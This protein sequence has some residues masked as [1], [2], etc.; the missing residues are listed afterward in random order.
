M[1]EVNNFAICF[2]K[3]I[4]ILWTV[5]V[6]EALVVI[7]G[8]FALGTHLVADAGTKTGKSAFKVANLLNYGFL[9]GVFIIWA[10][11]RRIREL[12]IENENDVDRTK[13]VTI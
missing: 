12:K 7:F 10:L 13:C 8:V 4:R 2:Q 3:S 11:H 6:L 1:K 9:L 5:L